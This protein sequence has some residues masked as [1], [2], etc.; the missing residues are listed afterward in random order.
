MGVGNTGPVAE[1]NIQ[2]DPEAASYVFE[3]GLP[4]YMV[5]LEITHQ[6]L[7]TREIIEKIRA[8]NSNLSVILCELLL[9]FK[10]T[11]KTVF[12]MD[13]PPLHDPVAVAAVVDPSLFEFKLMRVD[14]ETGSLLSYGQTVC[15]IYGMSNKKKNVYVCMSMNVEK[16]WSLMFDVIKKADLISPCNK[17]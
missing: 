9:F 2:V 1:F 6:A 11:Y 7:V 3:S 13:E 4:I 16:F 8:L 14:I 5:P 10:S 15:D 12:F 17:R